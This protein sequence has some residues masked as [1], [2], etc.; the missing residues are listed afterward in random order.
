MAREKHWKRQDGEKRITMPHERA[1]L[2][3]RVPVAE[4]TDRYPHTS[5]PL[6]IASSEKQAWLTERYRSAVSAQ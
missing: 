1:P 4:P 6:P 3:E 2:L 5:V